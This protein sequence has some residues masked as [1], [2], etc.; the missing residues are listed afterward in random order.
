MFDVQ[1]AA[2]HVCLALIKDSEE[3]FGGEV[4]AVAW[5]QALVSLGLCC[6]ATGMWQDL[7]LLAERPEMSGDLRAQLP[8]VFHGQL[9]VAYVQLGEWEEG[10]VL[11][12]TYPAEHWIALGWR[13]Q[14]AHWALHAH[15]EAGLKGLLELAREGHPVGEMAVRGLLAGCKQ[16]GWQETVRGVGRCDR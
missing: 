8:A 10:R 3:C 1:E 2:V 16:G 13:V 5:R 7:L 14:E 9:L 15:A 11:D 12:G 4:A 6:T